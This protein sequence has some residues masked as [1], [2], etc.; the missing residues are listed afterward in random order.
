MNCDESLHKLCSPVRSNHFHIFKKFY[1]IYLFLAVLSLCCCMGFLQL[2]RAGAGLRLWYA[3]FSL[4]RLL[5]LW[6]TGSRA[7]GL[8][9]FGSWALEH[10]LYSC[11]ARAQLLHNMWDFPG[12]EIEPMSSVLAGGFFTTEP[13]GKPPF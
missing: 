6:S 7:Y 10:R 12:S 3:D 9:S 4:Q 1:F 5:L 8:N 2:Q 11:D 13:S